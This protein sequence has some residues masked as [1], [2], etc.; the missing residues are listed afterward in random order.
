MPVYERG[1]THWTCPPQAKVDPPWWVI[2]RRGLLAPLQRRAF[3]LLLF[4]A[5]VPAIVKGSIIYIKARAGQLLDLATGSSWT[6]IDPAG[7]LAFVEGQR[8]IV[9][10]FTTLIGARLIARDR[11]EN[12]LALYF[13]RPLSLGDYVAGKVR[14]R[15]IRRPGWRCHCPRPP[16]Q[17]ERRW[18]R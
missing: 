10:L 7:F 12:G 6:S 3:L 4:M 16:R 17:L 8:F 9:F 13:S 1:Y 15:A 14:Q 18:R 11:Q 5:W 2:A